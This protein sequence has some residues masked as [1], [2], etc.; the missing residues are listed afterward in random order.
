MEYLCSQPLILPSGYE[1]ISNPSKFFKPGRVFKILWPELAGAVDD[2]TTV[3]DD[4]RFGEKILAKIRWFMVVSDG[5]GACTAV[6][7]HTYNDRGVSKFGVMAKEHAP[8]VLTGKDPIFLPGE[9]KKELLPPLHLI[10]EQSERLSDASRINFGKIYTIEHN[11]KVKSV[12]R[13]VPGDISKL[14]RYVSEIWD[15]KIGKGKNRLPN[16]SHASIQN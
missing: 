11:T 1:R 2:D 10:L 16:Q 12:G 8:L 6:P 13:I 14:K 15:T 9:N 7:I 3:T 4:S 5:R